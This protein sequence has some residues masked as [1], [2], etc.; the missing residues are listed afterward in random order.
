M[1]GILLG[2]FL[3]STKGCDV[4]LDLAISVACIYYYTCVCYLACDVHCIVEFKSMI[5]ALREIFVCSNRD[6]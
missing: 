2:C 1:F 3:A 4:E 5:S 6:V